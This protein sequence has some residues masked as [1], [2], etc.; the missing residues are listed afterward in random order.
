VLRE[1]ACSAH[2]NVILDSI[3]HARTQHVGVDEQVLAIYERLVGENEV[4]ASDNICEMVDDIEILDVHFTRAWI[5]EVCFDE[6]C[7]HIDE[8]FDVVNGA[9][10]EVVDHGD[11]ASELLHEH[12]NEVVPHKASAASDQHA[13]VREVDIWCWWVAG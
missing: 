13:F 2:I 6:V 11:I 1:A 5:G 4:N 7:R 3:L 10:P 9:T 8:I 12:T